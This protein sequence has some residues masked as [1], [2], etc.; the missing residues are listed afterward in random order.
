[1]KFN[2]KCQKCRNIE[3]QVLEKYLQNTMH[4]GITINYNYSNQ[5]IIIWYTPTKKYLQPLLILCSVVSGIFV[6]LDTVP[7]TLWWDGHISKMGSRFSDANRSGKSGPFR[8][9]RS[10]FSRLTQS[11]VGWV[12]VNRLTAVE[13]LQFFQ[14]NR[15]LCV[16][17]LRF[18][19]EN[20]V[21]IF[22]H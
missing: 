22:V 21:P 4:V 9:K 20:R 12:T 6:A 17:L 5:I 14:F 18:S 10:G 3:C 11:F 2:S 16:Q 15:K 1:M 19:P 13:Q 8:L 7:K